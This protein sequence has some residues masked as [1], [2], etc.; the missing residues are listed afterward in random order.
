MSSVTEGRTALALHIPKLGIGLAY[1]TALHAFIERF[2]TTFDFLEIVPDILW[3]DLGPGQGCRYVE[4]SNAVEFLNKVR[5]VIPVI[6]HSIGLSIGSAHRFNSEHVAQMARWYEWLR[7][8]WHS[9]HL[10]FN[11]TELGQAEVNGGVMMPLPLDYETLDLL[12]SHIHKVQHQIEAPFLL[13]NNVYYVRFIE[14]DLEE[15]E[16]LNTLCHRSGCGL[17]LDLHNVY[18]NSRNHHHSAVAFLEQLDLSCVVELHVAGGM[19]YE[20]FYLDAHSGPIPPPVWELLEWTLPLCPN[21][22]GV[23]FEL[24]GSWFP[25][26]GEDRLR[27]DL[28]RMREL[29]LSH[30]PPPER[31]P[32]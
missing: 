20:G 1:Q 26:M 14:E 15:A 4:E 17:L 24:L 29:W 31:P 5:A 27:S 7:F 25:V 32:L 10:S 23:V 30:Q 13:E 8:P 16:F 12:V 22:G 3:T 11:L 6:P 28:Q 2:T 18:T 21:V 9:D 19:E